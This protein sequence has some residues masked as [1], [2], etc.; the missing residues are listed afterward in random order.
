MTAT[1]EK[2]GHLILSA[3][4]IAFA[5]RGRPEAEQELLDLMT[6]T[7]RM[8]S[9]DFAPEIG[10]SV[11]V[12]SNSDFAAEVEQVVTEGFELALTLIRSER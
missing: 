12:G 10:E 3:T 5:A 6:E 11:D 8:F 9:A 2:V 4:A 1:A 7:K